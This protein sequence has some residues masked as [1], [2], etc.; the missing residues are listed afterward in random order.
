M[1]AFRTTWRL[2]DL[3]AHGQQG[4]IDD[5]RARHRLLDDPGPV[6]PLR[7]DATGEL[8]TRLNPAF[9]TYQAA[10]HKAETALKAGANRQALPPESGSGRSERGR[11]SPTVSNSG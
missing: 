7:Q 3:G 8:R 11:R 1:P 10:L 6:S 5:I 4:A 2:V 9:N